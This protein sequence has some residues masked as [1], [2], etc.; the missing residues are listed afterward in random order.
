MIMITIK[1]GT[2]K[3]EMHAWALIPPRFQ[4]VIFHM[5]EVE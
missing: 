3:S 1:S 2:Q 5:W 4:L